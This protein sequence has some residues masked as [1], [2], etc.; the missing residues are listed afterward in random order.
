MV[1]YYEVYQHVYILFLFLHIFHCVAGISVMRCIAMAMPLKSRIIITFRNTKILV[2]AC[3]VFVTVTLL[4]VPF[5]FGLVTMK[6]GKT[7]SI[8]CFAYQT[9]SS[10]FATFYFSNVRKWQVCQFKSYFTRHKKVGKIYSCPHDGAF[11]LQACS[12]LYIY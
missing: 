5:S 2:I 6:M 11:H 3:F 1:H 12:R 9:G 8:M 7:S 4:H 10:E